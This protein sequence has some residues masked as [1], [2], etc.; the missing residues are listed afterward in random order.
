MR[1][2]GEEVRPVFLGGRIDNGIRRRELVLVP[3]LGGLQGDW[4]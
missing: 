4:V 2:A 3:Q 1:I